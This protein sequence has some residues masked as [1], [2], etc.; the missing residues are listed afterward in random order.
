MSLSSS[1][2]RKQIS[3]QDI[4]ADKAAAATES[5]VQIG[6]PL[7]PLFG[8]RDPNEGKP[9]W[10][11][12]VRDEQG[13]RRF[14]G[15]FTGGWSAG[16]FNT[17]GSKEGWT[18]QAFVSSRGDRRAEGSSSG[19]NGSSG[20]PRETP[21][22][23]ARPEDFMD[24]ED[25]AELEERRQM[26]NKAGYGSVGAPSANR[27]GD[28]EVLG[29]LLG[30]GKQSTV[31]FEQDDAGSG[32][33]APSTSLGRKILSRMGWQNGSGLGPRVTQK[34]RS[35]LLRLF[36]NREN[37]ST[38][39]STQH[40]DDSK[41]IHLPPD[42]PM[43][44]M[45]QNLNKQDTYGLGW[46]RKPGLASETTQRVV[47]AR[48]A[49]TNP[50][51]FDISVLEDADEDD[52]ND[53]YATGESLSDVI[54]RRK[55]EA[56]S[57]ST[58][59][60]KRSKDL[61][62]DGT[63]KASV[64]VPAQGKDTITDPTL[65]GLEKIA[66]IDVPPGWSPDPFKVWAKAKGLQ[67]PP[68]STQ[69][70]AISASPQ[71]PGQTNAAGRAQ[72]LGEAPMP[73]PPPSLANYL[74]P[75]T[76]NQSKP[77]S[78]PDRVDLPAVDTSTAQAALKGFMPFG[79]EEAKQKRYTAFLE[80]C[81]DP[82]SSTQVPCPPGM[83]ALETRTELQEF[84]RSANIFKPLSSAMAN[85][86]ASAKTVEGQ[87]DVNAPAPGLYQPAPRSRADIDAE[88]R[89]R[90]QEDERRLQQEKEE[91]LTD[92][93]KA[94][95]AG[96]FGRA[97][98]REVSEWFPPKL[99]CKRLGIPDPHP[100]RG[101]GA[102]ATDSKGEDG[103]APSA[104]ESDD[105]FNS[106]GR[107][108]KLES[109]AAR[110]EIQRGEDRWQKSRREL[111]DIAGERRWEDRG[112]L[113]TKG[114]EGSADGPEHGSTNKDQPLPLDQV[115]LGEGSAD[116]LDEIANFVKPA[117]SLFKSVFASDE[118]DE[119][120]GEE[121]KEE[122]LGTSAPERM[123]KGVLTSGDTAAAPVYVPRASG[124]A[125]SDKKAKRKKK[126]SGKGA[127]ALTFTM[128]DG[129]EEEEPGIVKKAKKRQP[130]DGKGKGSSDG[131]AAA[132]GAVSGP[133]EG[134]DEPVTAQTRAGRVRASD[135]F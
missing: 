16:Y 62:Q 114:L 56:S 48:Q 111:L 82:S 35:W 85:R 2:L 37:R 126:S 101:G 45:T 86:F 96:L 17:V 116:Q 50:S 89:K 134:A 107:R 117:R 105:P 12:E 30:L 4:D 68:S 60:P 91:S 124:T 66:T 51:G 74:T 83:S 129:D 70:T 15:A 65:Q 106:N 59:M 135:L 123:R 81:A 22:R 5:F 120:D 71:Q 24:E 25:L 61:R 78:E 133:R 41:A 90:E 6:T 92:K 84:A 132:V 130:E 97:T 118:E 18:P 103:Q 76:S 23:Q 19:Q 14:H 119:D 115:G 53:I 87:G 46:A 10:E 108:E 1:K 131:A 54:A 121:A 7:P 127:G 42:T 49:P 122:P 38:V 75:S 11:Q 102:T 80:V 64:F 44:S 8:S 40:E 27:H 57:G 95:R 43:P 104:H 34:R 31:A 36:G 69:P 29:D 125:D 112:G 3:R 55:A 109:S 73:G 9:V 33:V 26:S 93:Q 113:P 98:T 47:E 39:G 128:D 79:K 94:A 110:R 88:A 99:L 21:S 32:L 77:K 20:V 67:L 63:D 100:N 58:G 28:D 52:V 72:M 13:R